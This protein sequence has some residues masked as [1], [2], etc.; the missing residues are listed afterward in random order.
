VFIGVRDNGRLMQAFGVNL[1][2]TRLASFAVSGGIAGLAGALFAYQARTVDAETYTPQLS[3]LLFAV[4]VIGGMG[5]VTGAIL[6][7]VVVLGTP[8]LPG[9]RDIEN[10]DLLLSG[11]G[12]VW[13]PF[14]LPGGLAEGV[15]RMRDEWL[16]RLAARHG[17][18]VPSLVADS[19]VTG[20]H[21]ESVDTIVGG[22]G[23]IE[24]VGAPA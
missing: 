24:L 23:D 22:A 5:T 3:I 11:I 1:A 9:I 12:L 8:L 19:L 21:E 20:E 15:F 4:V 7:T 18:H 14:V 10:I 6:G 17:L 16:R 2:R 13:I